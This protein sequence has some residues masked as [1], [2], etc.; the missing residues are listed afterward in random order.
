MCKIC[1]Y[2][3]VR[4]KRTYIEIHTGIKDLTVVNSNDELGLWYL[5]PPASVNASKKWKVCNLSGLS[6]GQQLGIALDLLS[7]RC[8]TWYDY[9]TKAA[10]GGIQ[11]RNGVTYFLTSHDLLKLLKYNDIRLQAFTCNKKLIQSPLI[12]LWLSERMDYGTTSYS[13]FLIR[14][15]HIRHDRNSATKCILTSVVLCS[16]HTSIYNTTHGS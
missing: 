10:H 12:P 13:K 8:L 6:F 14:T 16:W 3:Y 11:R 2:S 9:D 7:H 4:E 5:L 15:Q 1:I